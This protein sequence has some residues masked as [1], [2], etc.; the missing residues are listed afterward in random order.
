MVIVNCG[1]CGKLLERKL[2]RGDR[3][4]CRGKCQ[5]YRRLP[6]SYVCQFDECRR[7]FH[8]KESTR[9]TFC[10]REHAFA[11]KA[12]QSYL[13]Q[14][15]KLIRQLWQSQA[16]TRIRVCIVCGRV[17]PIIDYR[18]TICSKDCIRADNRE[19][20]KDWALKHLGRIF[21]CRE[22]GKEVM[23][24]YGDKRRD[25]C[26]KRHGRRYHQRLSWI[27][28]GSDSHRA[29]ARRAG[30]AYE[31]IRRF[32]VFQRDGWRCRHCGR[33]VTVKGTHL[34]DNY[35]ELDHI[36]PFAKGGG[37]LYKN[38]QTLCRQCNGKKGKKIR[39]E[40]LLLV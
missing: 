15:G 33:K 3:F 25:F 9:N 17:F 5:Y 20:Y 35:A 27:R 6:V 28:Y 22:C 10:C 16:M 30:M 36:V 29:R 23:A 26:S 14:I 11:A 1:I 8:P 2:I 34:K 32:V 13:I 38:V 24:E 19:R 18:Q 31:V 4:Y 39:N 12:K 37:H 7:I 40:Q 21:K